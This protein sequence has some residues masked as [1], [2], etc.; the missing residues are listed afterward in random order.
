MTPTPSK[1]D[2]HHAR[3][4][5]AAAERKAYLKKLAAEH[6]AR[7]QGVRRR[8]E[9]IRLQRIARVEAIRNQRT[10]G[11]KVSPV[12]PNLSPTAVRTIAEPVVRGRLIKPRVVT[13]ES[14]PAVAPA[15]EPAP[16]AASA[17]QPPSPDFSEHRLVRGRVVRAAGA[18]GAP[19][20]EA[21]VRFPAV[22]GPVGTEQAPPEPAEP[23]T[24]PELPV[25]ADPEPLPSAVHE[26]DEL[27]DAVDGL[28]PSEA[29]P[30]PPPSGRLRRALEQPAPGNEAPS[31]PRLRPIRAPKL[32]KS[33]TLLSQDFEELP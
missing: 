1:N 17:A 9:E 22:P 7:T 2:D 8:L 32:L 11:A 21:E 23:E 30:E 3:A 29:S 16:E 33:R 28:Q 31:R 12:P 14:V 26:V 4:A 10:T 20:A 25:A 5:A 6:L 27:M 15:V 18:T 19:L 24:E 13:P